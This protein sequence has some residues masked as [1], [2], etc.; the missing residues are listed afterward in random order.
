MRPSVPLLTSPL[1]HIAQVA[2]SVRLKRELVPGGAPSTHAPPVGAAMGEDELMDSSELQLQR[3][4]VPVPILTLLIVLSGLPT[5][6]AQSPSGGRFVYANDDDWDWAADL[7]RSERTALSTDYG[8]TSWSALDWAEEGLKKPVRGVAIGSLPSSPE[9]TVK[10]LSKVRGAT[11][12]QLDANAGAIASAVKTKPQ[13]LLMMSDSAFGLP[14]LLSDDDR[15]VLVSYLKG[16]GRLVVLDD[17]GRYGPILHALI[18]HDP[19]SLFNLPAP[20][21]GLPHSPPMP[22]V[23]GGP[24]LPSGAA[25]GVEPVDLEP[26]TPG[27]VPNELVDGLVER[28]AAWG[29]AETAPISRNS[30]HLEGR[31]LR[32]KVK[33][34]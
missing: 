14:V 19:I 21:A 5:D 1:V 18:E 16:G 6:P 2:I 33:V 28:F 3:R 12:T 10:T 20:R 25:V 7:Q 34:R 4:L 32:L 9:L 23:P 11:W 29:T 15:R 27:G 26:S 17:G 8:V 30:G 31:A 22:G 13:V 24:R